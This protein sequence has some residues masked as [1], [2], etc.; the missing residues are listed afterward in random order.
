PHIAAKLGPAGG[1]RAC[2][3]PDAVHRLERCRARD[4]LRAV[5]GPTA[6][7]VRGGCGRPDARPL[8]SFDEAPSMGTRAIWRGE[9]AGSGIAPFPHSSGFPRS[10]SS[11]A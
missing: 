7:N 2:F 8:N 10:A 4:H 1:V 3:G 11:H 5:A 9:P 6:D